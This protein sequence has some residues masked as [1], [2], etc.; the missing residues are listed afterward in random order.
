MHCCCTRV[1]YQNASYAKRAPD[2]SAGN[3]TETRGKGTPRSLK[4]DMRR[5]GLLILRKKLTGQRTR[6][7]TAMET[8]LPL[9][10]VL[11]Q[12]PLHC[13]LV[14]WHKQPSPMFSATNTVVIPALRQKVKHLSPLAPEKIFSQRILERAQRSAKNMR[15]TVSPKQPRPP[16]AF[17]FP[18]IFTCTGVSCFSLN[19]CF[20]RRPNTLLEKVFHDDIPVSGNCNAGECLPVPVSLRTSRPNELQRQVN[21]SFACRLVPTMLFGYPAP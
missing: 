7:A 9:S 19:L 12:S 17:P 14:V 15:K 20:V 8:A 21:I 2:V 1:T 5:T 6:A 10:G 4:R 11:G 13:C 16:K 3:G 18:M